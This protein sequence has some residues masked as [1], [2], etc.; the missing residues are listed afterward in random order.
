MYA[1]KVVL[2]WV[3]VLLPTWLYLPLWF[4]VEYT[5]WP[6]FGLGCLT[7]IYIIGQATIMLFAKQSKYI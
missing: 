7:P 4:M 6:Y 5:P 2:I 1:W 3:A